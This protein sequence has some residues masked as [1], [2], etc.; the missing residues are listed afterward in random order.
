M[1]ACF[2]DPRRIK[3]GLA[4]AASG[5]HV[6]LL[7]TLT[8]FESDAPMLFDDKRRSAVV[9]HRTIRTDSQYSPKTWKMLCST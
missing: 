1:R 5:D 2:N 3:P 8:E 7:L 6:L 4:A 9:P